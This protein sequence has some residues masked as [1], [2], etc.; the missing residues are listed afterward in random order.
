MFTDMTTRLERAGHCQR[1]EKYRRTTKQCT[2]CGCL[3]NLKVT[4]SNESCPLGKWTRAPEG[5]D[6]AAEVSSKLKEFFQP[7]K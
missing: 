6:F 3:V 2:E 4:L 1:C 5:K 7:K